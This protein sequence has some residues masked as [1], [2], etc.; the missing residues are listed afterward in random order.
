[1][2]ILSRE[3]TLYYY[4]RKKY[5]SDTMISKTKGEDV[6]RPGNIYLLVDCSCSIG[7]EIISVIVGT[8]KEIAKSCGPFSRIIWWDTDLAGD[9]PLKSF[10]GPSTYGGTTI[11]KGIE[12]VRQKYLKRSNDKLIIL[13]DYYD[14]LVHWYDEL[15][16]IKNDCVGICWG[17]F[18]G[19]K[20]DVKFMKERS[21]TYDGRDI[22]ADLMKKLPTTLVNVGKRED[23]Y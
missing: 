23:Y 11:W 10:K 9:Y 18:E 7:S 17:N 1:M 22:Y 3:D 12:Y 6:Y 13:S 19:T 4:N 20:I 14:S 16:K 21:T 2:K 8:V 5:N 15:C